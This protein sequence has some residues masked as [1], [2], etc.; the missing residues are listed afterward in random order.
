[1]KNFKFRYL[2]FLCLVA[3][4]FSCSNDGSTPIYPIKKYENPLPGFL[5]ASGFDEENATITDSPVNYE[6]GFKFIPRKVGQITAF[7]VKIPKTS[8]DIRVTIWDVSEATVIKTQHIKVTTANTTV[9]VSIAPFPLEKDH[10]YMISMNTKDFYTHSRTDAATAT[11]PYTVGN[12]DVTGSAY[13]LGTDQ[14]MPDNAILDANSGD[15]SF[16]FEETEDAPVAI[17]YSPENPLA[18]YL[19]NSGFSETANDVIASGDSEIGY[20]FK[21]LSPG[22][23]SEL[24]VNIPVVNPAVRVTLWDSATQTP[25]LTETVAVTVAGTAVTKAITPIIL[26]SGKTYMISMQTDSWISHQKTDLSD[27]VYPLTAGNISILKHVKTSGSAQVYPT[28]VVTANYFGD[29]SF[30][31]TQTSEK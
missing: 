8:D 19:I 14:V 18:T 30:S 1:M 16:V 4:V 9:V 15:V 5:K 20:E 6:T 3:I 24:T 12:F 27:A 11:Y 13:R 10:E 2:F 28:D 29:V 26:L 21:P 17:L 25:I 31:F 7:G 22:K 23:I